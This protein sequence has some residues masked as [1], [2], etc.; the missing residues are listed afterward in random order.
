[1]FGVQ[2]HNRASSG[3]KRRHSHLCSLRK[4]RKKKKTNSNPNSTLSP[5]I[6]CTLNLTAST[7]SSMNLPISFSSSAPGSPTTGAQSL[8]REMEGCA[9]PEHGERSSEN[10]WD[11]RNAVWR[12]LSLKCPSLF[13]A[14]T[15]C[16]AWSSWGRI[17]TSLQWTVSQKSSV[18]V[19]KVLLSLKINRVGRLQWKLCVSG[20]RI[21]L[22]IYN[23]WLQSETWMN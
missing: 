19:T 20:G 6:Q 3:K 18:K 1:M 17:F 7:R 5:P 14:D 16:F 21:W 2:G 9:R 15:P 10:H 22:S 13:Q 4:L 12:L 11:E 8:S 23:R